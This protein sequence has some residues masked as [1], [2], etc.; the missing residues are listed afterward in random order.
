MKRIDLSTTLFDEPMM[1]DN[2]LKGEMRVHLSQPISVNLNDTF[3]YNNSQ[4]PQNDTFLS[5]QQQQQQQKYYHSNEEKERSEDSNLINHG[6]NNKK[7]MIGGG[8]SQKDKK[9]MFEN[10]MKMKTL[11]NAEREILQRSQIM[12]DV[13]EVTLL[14]HRRFLST[15]RRE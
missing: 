11:K 6:K 15:D 8:L 2:I 10:A 4:T 3:L 7:N 14:V 13:R 1:D 5:Q 12:Y 9:K